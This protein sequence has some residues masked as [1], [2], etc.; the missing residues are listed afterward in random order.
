MTRGFSSPDYTIVAHVLNEDG[1]IYDK[2]YTWEA[3]QNYAIYEGRK[4]VAVADDGN[5]TAADAQRLYDS[6]LALHLDCWDGPL[7]LAE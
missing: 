3:G 6:E 2:C 7:Y 4:V 5:M 1:T